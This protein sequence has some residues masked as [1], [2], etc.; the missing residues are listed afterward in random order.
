MNIFKMS[1]AVRQISTGGTGVIIGIHPV[2]P[3]TSGRTVYTVQFNFGL[4]ESRVPQEDLELFHERRSGNDRRVFKDRRQFVI[5][6]Y[7]GQCVLESLEKAL[8]LPLEDIRTMFYESPSGQRDPSNLNDVTAV[9]MENDY[10]VGLISENKA[11]RKGERCFVTLRNA[12]GIGHA[13][14]VFEDNTVFDAEGKFNN[15]GNFYEQCLALGWTVQNVL[16]L[17]K[18]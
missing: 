2:L 11:D 8:E 5:V 17:K 4:P 15:S 6:K 13:V 3:P 10:V 1:D 7:Q 16:L 12:A 9:L 18:M 14:V